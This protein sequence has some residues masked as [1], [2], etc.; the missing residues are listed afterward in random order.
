MLNPSSF[1]LDTYKHT[2]RAIIIRK[3]NQAQKAGAGP[4]G[5]VGTFPS[6]KWT[7]GE[8]QAETGLEPST[9]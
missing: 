3:S 2:F 6:V 8:G 7:S 5:L 9:V 1:S 4:K